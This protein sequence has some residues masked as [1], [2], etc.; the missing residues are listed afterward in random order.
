[1]KTNLKKLIGTAV[2]GLTL[3]THSLPTWAGYVQQQFIEVRIETNQASGSMVGA[4]YSGDSQQYI[5]CTSHNPAVT[6]S[7]RD[8]TG[9][10]LL[11]TKIDPQWVA[12]VRTIT[13]S[14]HISFALAPGT[15]TCDSLTIKNGSRFLK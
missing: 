9:R 8:K 2:L 6:C 5:T 13:D 3:F 15:Q 7:A 1:M 12:A 4:R 11:C 14:S 10:Y